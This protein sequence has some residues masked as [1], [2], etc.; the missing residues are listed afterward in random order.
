VTAGYHHT[1]VLHND[2]IACFGRNLESQAD[3]S[4][5]LVDP[6]NDGVDNANDNCAYIYNQN[7]KDT[8]N[9]GLGDVCD[10]DD[11]N[12]GLSDADETGIHGTDP[13]LTDSDGDRLNDNEEINTHGTNPVVAD[14]DS[15]GSDDYEEILA[16]TDPADP[17]VRPYWWKTLHG[18]A[19]GD[20]F[21]YSVSSVGDLN[22]DGYSEIIVGAHNNDS[23]AAQGGAA[24]LYD[25]QN[26]NLLYKTVGTDSSGEYGKS[27][28]DV[29]DVNMDG[30]PDYIV[31]AASAD[32]NLNNMVG[33]ATVYSGL[34]NSVLYSEQGVEEFEYFGD[35]VS[36]AGDLNGD[37]YADFIVGA[38]LYNGGLSQRGRF[39]VFSGA[40]GSLIYEKMGGNGGD[41]LGFSVGRLGDVNDDGFDD[42]LA[43]S[44]NID[45]GVAYT[46]QVRV[47]SGATG[48]VLFSVA[49]DSEQRIGA[50]AEGV[51]DVNGDGVADFVTGNPYDLLNG[52]NFG[53][54]TLVNGATGTIIYT[55]LGESKSDYLG[56]S[57]GSVG[58]VNNDGYSDFMVGIPR[59][60]TWSEDAGM[61]RVYS[62]IDG[63]VLQ[64]LF[65]GFT[66][67]NFGQSVSSMGDM[68]G[69]GYTDYVVGMPEGDTTGLVQIILSSAFVNDRD[70]DFYSNAVDPFPD[71]GTEWSDMDGDGV[72]DNTDLCN[73]T[74]VL[75]S[76]NDGDGCDD[77]TEDSDDDNDGMPDAWEI[78]HGLNSLDDSDAGA[79]PDNDGWTNLEEYLNG[80][81]PFV[82]AYRPDSSSADRDSDDDL[83]WKHITHDII[84]TTEIENSLNQGSVVDVNNFPTSSDLV[85]YGDTDGDRDVDYIFR[86]QYD[87]RVTLLVME[88]HAVVESVDLGLFNLG[89][90]LV[91]TGDTDGDGDDDMV[92]YRADM[93]RTILFEMENNQK[94]SQ[95]WVGDFFQLSYRPVGLGD[96]DGDGDDDL[97]WSRSDLLNYEPVVVWW[98]ENNDRDPVNDVDWL[99]TYYNDY[100][101]I[102][103]IGDFDGDGDDDP[104]W[105][106]SADGNVVYWNIQDPDGAHTGI[107]P[108]RTTA[109][110][111]GTF[112]NLSWQIV[113]SGDTDAD[114]T[115][116]LF[117][118]NASTGGVNIWEI[119]NFSRTSVHSLFGSSNTDYVPV[120]K[121]NS[122]VE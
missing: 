45:V 79:D 27:V 68:D 92:W 17:D 78:T 71:D 88:D 57:V 56:S 105:Y 30:Y 24:Y 87:G 103:A 23:G 29:G 53:S 67:G 42:F 86:S 65:G 80:T 7:Q 85:G 55:I 10:S 18:E 3:T 112:A 25:G 19:S 84:K 101:S 66:G 47:Y 11:D 14:G 59:D 8:D 107:R 102:A 76:D 113:H 70:M 38:R 32:Y 93:G 52:I 111:V 58:D 22:A 48:N 90:T 63:A 95:N 9:D 43:G 15:D 21:G 115:D 94:I 110:W 33:R 75:N 37:G 72:G 41:T 100:Y 34:D 96:V 46:G 62:G 97:W 73:A 82:A 16:G 60:D 122:L 28:N 64:T 106:S 104:I 118:H 13:L 39:K 61:V 31:G 4:S 49:G 26:G 35:A 108:Q 6:D 44:P 2:G 109:G 40:D 69:D 119:D 51:G 121:Y 116:D 36:G 50:K 99:N 83:I 74:P 1:C 89:Y 117:W 77:A 81:D 98:F 91:G 12:D 114:Q 20:K 120:P 5:L 54:A